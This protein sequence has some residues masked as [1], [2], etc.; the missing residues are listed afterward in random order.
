MR[1]RAIAI[2]THRVPLGM[3]NPTRLPLPTPASANAAAKSRVVMSSS[4]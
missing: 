3:I 1:V 2:W 4:R